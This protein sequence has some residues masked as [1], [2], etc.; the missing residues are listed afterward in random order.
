M[1]ITDSPYE[2][3]ITFAPEGTS[4]SIIRR[5][6]YMQVAVARPVELVWEIITKEGEPF[7]PFFTLS[8]IE[9]KY[10][11][12]AF[13]EALEPYGKKREKEIKMKAKMDAMEQHL[14]DLR[15][16]IKALSGSELKRRISL[17]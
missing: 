15:Q 16:I 14:E 6:G 17:E 9:A 8:H 13:K 7:K 4:I 3:I 1:S 2:V 5:Q 10:L 12:D 11:L